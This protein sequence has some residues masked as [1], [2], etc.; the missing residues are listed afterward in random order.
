MSQRYGIL[1]CIWDNENV[2]KFSEIIKANNLKEAIEKTDRNIE[3]NI[4]IPLNSENIKHLKKL[5][6][7]KP[8]KE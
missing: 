5:I 8:K 4:V 1:Y 6:E 2:I 3:L 7:S